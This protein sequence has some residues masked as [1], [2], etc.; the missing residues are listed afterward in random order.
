V[1]DQIRSK[2][3]LFIFPFASLFFVLL[4]KKIII[5][6]DIIKKIHR[7]KNPLNHR[8]EM[9]P[10]AV[11]SSS[12]YK[13]LP[14]RHMSRFWYIGILDR[15]RKY[16]NLWNIRIRESMGFS[17]HESFGRTFVRYHIMTMWVSEY[18]L[19]RSWSQCKIVGNNNKIRPRSCS[20]ENIILGMTVCMSMSF[21]IAVT[22]IIT[23]T[24]FV[25]V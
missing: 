10:T 14:N 17:S 19:F 22:R 13:F 21:I 23:Q 11:V 9:E 4:M 24:S 20:E 7:K 6:S 1:A 15:A 2:Y 12:H 5:E 16:G 8:I 3:F 18:F 25:I